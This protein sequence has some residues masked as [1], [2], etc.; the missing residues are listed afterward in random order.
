MYTKTRKHSNR[1]HAD[2]HRAVQC[3]QLFCCM[4]V[5]C[6]QLSELQQATDRQ[7]AVLSPPFRASCLSR[8]GVFA[9]N[10]GAVTPIGVLVSK[11]ITC[12]NVAAQACNHNPGPPQHS[13][14]PPSGVPET[15]TA[16]STGD[17]QPRKTSNQGSLC[18]PALHPKVR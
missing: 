4:F 7:T 13:K 14:K 16:A 18:M 12:C 2:I 5:Q 8:R 15:Q 6:L 1:S 11:T 17:F 9:I 3:H 10:A